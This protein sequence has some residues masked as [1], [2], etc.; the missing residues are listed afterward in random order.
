MEITLPSSRVTNPYGGPEQ[1]LV[2]QWLQQQIL[3]QVHNHQLG[4]EVSLPIDIIYPSSNRPKHYTCTTEHV[5]WLKQT[6]QGCFEEVRA[7]L[8]VFASRQRITMTRSK[9]RSF[10]QGDWV[11]RFYPP[12]LSRSKLNPQYVGSYLVVKQLGEVTYQIQEGPQK[13]TSSCPC[14]SFKIPRFMVKLWDKDKHPWLARERWP[15]WKFYT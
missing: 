11:L 3:K 7:H 13:T 8:S 15:F 1:V 2:P 6:M 12:G 9:P 10:K 14:W 4:G 5:E